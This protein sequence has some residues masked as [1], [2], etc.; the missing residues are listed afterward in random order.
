[1]GIGAQT[2]SITFADNGQG[3][4]LWITP[5]YK[6]QD[7]DGFNADGINYGVDM[8]LYGLALGADYTLGNGLR[9]GALFNVGSGDADG[10][11]AGSSVSND[12]DYYGFGIYAGYTM[13]KFSV[14]AD[15]TYTVVDNDLEVSNMADKLSAS[16]DTSNLSVGVTGQYAFDFNGMN[17]VPHAGLRY[18]NIDMDDYKVNGAKF[19]EIANYSADSMSVFS[20][21][22]G[23]TFSKEFVSGEWTVKPAFDLTLTA[24]MGDD[25]TEGNVSWAGISNVGCHVESEVVDSFT[26]GATL[27]VAAKTNNFSLG[28]GINY[29]GSSNVDEL[30]V[31]ANARFVF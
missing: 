2:G 17:V 4:G 24:N 27:G 21:P 20:I 1:M 25:A 13:D 9:V 28:F 14:V 31:N 6:S 8:D 16:T 19:G 7:S 23:V 11:G 22:V 15:V 18:T 3:S 5:V 10:Q 26:Y 30:G 29:T 12:F